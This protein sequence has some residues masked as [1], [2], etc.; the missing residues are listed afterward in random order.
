MMMMLMI[1]AVPQTIPPTSDQEQIL[2][3]GQ[4]ETIYNLIT[5]IQSFHIGS[6]EIFLTFWTPLLA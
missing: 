5:L 2:P 1:Q 4:T 3:S 6:S